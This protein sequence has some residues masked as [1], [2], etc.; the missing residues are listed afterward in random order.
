MNSGTGCGAPT[1]PVPARFV[2]VR[3]LRRDYLHLDQVEVFGE[4]LPGF[5]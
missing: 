5:G 2:R 4:A 3:L 1:I